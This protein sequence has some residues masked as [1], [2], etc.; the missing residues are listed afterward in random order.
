MRRSDELMH[1]LFKT[2]A[3]ATPWTPSA[4]AFALEARLLAALRASRPVNDG[5]ELL[6]VL[7]IGLGLASILTAVIIAFSLREM[8]KQPAAELVLPNAA[9]NLSLTQ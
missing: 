2:A 7:R 1:R 9:L 5:R 8:A 3:Q 4:P 6:P